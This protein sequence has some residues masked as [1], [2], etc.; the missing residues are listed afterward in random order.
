M[1]G[2]ADVHLRGPQGC[3]EVTACAERR[4]MPMITL[5]VIHSRVRLMA[6]PDVL[7]GEVAAT[8]KVLCC[9]SC[10]PRET[11]VGGVA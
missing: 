6:H 3:Q 9:D 1:K 2:S 11:A 10:L 5:S 8:P 4:L 7:D